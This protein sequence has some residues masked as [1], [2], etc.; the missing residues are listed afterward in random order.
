[1]TDR[2]PLFLPHYRTE[3]I[4]QE[5][6]QCFDIGW[7]GMGYKT[8]E[9]EKKWCEYTGL[10]FA[11]F[12][13]S[14]TAAIHT[15]V[16]VLKEEHGWQDGDEIITSPLT[17]V[18][19][20]HAVTYE[21]LN[22]VFADVDDSLSLAPEAVTARISPRTKAVIYVGLGGHAG[23]LRA[24]AALCQAKGLLLILDAAHM[25]GAKVDGRDP[26]HLADVSCYSFHAVKNLPTFDSGMVCFRSA[27]L[28]QRARQ[29]SWLG[30]DK[31]TFARTTD[32]FYNWKY[33]IDRVGYKYNGN[34]VAASV[35]LISLKYLDED[36]LRRRWISTSYREHFLHNPH[37]VLPLINDDGESDT[38]SANHLA[39][40]RVKERDKVIAF[41]QAHNVNCGVH[42][43]S[44]T[45]F[46]LF[47]DQYDSCPH[48]ATAADELISLPIFVGMSEEQLSAVCRI[49]EQGIHS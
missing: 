48:A 28:D 43:Q 14:C 34:S 10:P 23:N 25:A 19:T 30:I 29:F 18:S 47:R 37:I 16:A 6:R 40:I 9:F 8:D 22:V 38:F 42:Y 41:A 26:G 45:K 33:E 17:F 27:L 5:M 21:R 1:M 35:A 44:L 2:T 11:H 49:I 39:Q 15:A 32:R 7:T 13:N 3:E 20:A 46:E 24:I 36:N 12:V 4:L 31:S